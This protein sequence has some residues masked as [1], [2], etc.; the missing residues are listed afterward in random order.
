MNDI[1]AQEDWFPVLGMTV[2][3]DLRRW[4]A[5]FPM[6]VLMSLSSDSP[7]TSSN[8]MAKVGDQWKTKLMS[9]LQKTRLY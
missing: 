8:K 4:Q 9:A 7:T 6:T 1:T 2:L 5:F 3:C